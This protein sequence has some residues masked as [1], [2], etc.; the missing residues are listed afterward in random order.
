M[1]PWNSIPPFIRLAIWVWA[2]WMVGVAAISTVVFLVIALMW[3]VA[4][5]S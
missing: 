1:T 3:L 5:S 2:W 4:T